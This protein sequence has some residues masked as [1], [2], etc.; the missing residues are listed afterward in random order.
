MKKED[1][2]K[3]HVAL[4]VLGLI[5]MAS[6]GLAASKK[7]TVVEE[8]I[9][10]KLPPATQKPREI[11]SWHEAY[12]NDYKLMGTMLLKGENR[13]AAVDLAQQRGAH[14][15]KVNFS[16]TLITK[17]SSTVLYERPVGPGLKEVVTGKKMKESPGFYLEMYSPGRD[18]QEGA[19]RFCANTMPYALSGKGYY[20]CGT[21]EDMKRYLELGADPTPFLS[22]LVRAAYEIAGR[23]DMYRV[24]DVL[25]EMRRNLEMIVLTLDRGADALTVSGN[26]AYMLRL[27]ELRLRTN[28][29]QAG[30]ASQW[31]PQV[32]DPGQRAGADFALAFFVEVQ[33]IVDEWAKR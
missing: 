4:S 8:K 29:P 20:A 25:P 18:Y 5:L 12:L 11:W 3:K 7:V 2:M 28:A 33:R 26:T 31:P 22:R 9:L 32:A 13:E 30:D 10:E 17:F 21:M 19:K 24:S 27:L 23:A 6:S 15:V 14:L 1:L 16:K